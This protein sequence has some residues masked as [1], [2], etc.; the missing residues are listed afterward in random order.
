MLHVLLEL[1]LNRKL[2]PRPYN[3]PTTKEALL[4]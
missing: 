2:A 3:S 4:I 1:D